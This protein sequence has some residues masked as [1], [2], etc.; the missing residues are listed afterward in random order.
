M[1][2]SFD[3][4]YECQTDAQCDKIIKCKPKTIPRCQNYK[5]NFNAVFD[6]YTDP[7]CVNKV[8]C[9]APLIPICRN[10]KCVCDPHSGTKTTWS[11]RSK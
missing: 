2:A 4:F 11:E 9:K 8:K 7:Q 1:K 6:C 3:E 10:H 5:S